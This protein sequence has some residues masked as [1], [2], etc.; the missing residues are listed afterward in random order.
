[1]NE[2]NREKSFVLSRG[3]INE[4]AEFFQ[5]NSDCTTDLIDLKKFS[6][7]VDY[8]KY[9][10]WEKCGARPGQTVVIEFNLTNAYYFSAVFAAWELG[11]IM[12]ID[13]LH[14]RNQRDAEGSYFR[15]HGTIDIA[16][17]FSEQLR[18]G[19]KLYRPWDV[20][21][22]ELNCRQIITEK[23]FENYKITDHSLF[24]WVVD[25]VHANNHSDAIWTATSGSTGNP[26]QQRISHE[27]VYKQA[28]RL[29]DHLGIQ[30]GDSILHCN[31]LHHGASACYHFLPTLMRGRKHYLFSFDVENKAEVQDL[32]S[33]ISAYQINRAFLYSPQMILEYLRT[34]QPM[35]HRFDITT[36]LVCPPATIALAKQKKINVVH[37]MFGDTTIGYG[38]LVKTVHPQSQDMT[39]YNPMAIG[40]K[41]DDF[42]RFELRDENLYIAIPGLGQ[43]EWRTSYDRFQIINEEYV[44]LGRN[45]S[46]RIV[47]DWLNHS[48]IENK[49]QELF[50][51]DP[52][53]KATLIVDVEYQKIY[54]AVW[55]PNDPAETAIRQ[56]F[57]ERYIHARINRIERNLSK[58]DFMGSRKISRA[59]IREYF[60]RLHNQQGE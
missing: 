19:S 54:L 15:I 49:V 57:R 5:I 46:Y 17:V 31:N 28:Q 21:R 25:N 4:S 43:N 41:L 48:E 40:K 32:C 38:F 53:E 39:A 42:F 20:K 60:R 24:R 29:I 30:I 59:K 14:A 35:Q 47:D 37:A 50:A 7:L 58:T 12:I 2:S 44:F 34:T 3:L 51:G 23:D 6:G 11:L 36:L 18:P 27:A 26:K 45:N 10:L 52:D 13:W 56:W 33:H 8:W 9:L 16:I 22:T 55:E 1:M